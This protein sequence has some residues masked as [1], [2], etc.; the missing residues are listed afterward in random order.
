[1]NDASKPA[2][3]LD[4]VLG[5]RVMLHQPTVGYRVAIDPILL[6]AA[7]PAES[8][9][10]VVDLGCG[11]GTAA[12]CLARR[13][14]DVRCVGV[15]LQADL[16]DLANRNARENDLA[17]RARFLAGD[18]L[19][20]TLPI[21]AQPSD[22]VIVNPPY[23]KRGTATPSDNPAKVLAN[24]EGEADLA[25]WVAAAVRATRPGGTITFI[26]RADRL[27]DLLA[28]LGARCGGLVIQPLHPKAGAAAHRAI[29]AGRLDQRL[30]A[31]LLPGLIVHEA[32]GRF[33][34]LLERVL[35]DGAAL[36]M[37]VGV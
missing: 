11:V 37:T 33:S 18:I 1:M 19:D 31:I 25:A 29:V 2:T 35:R 7:C 17:D 26:H 28:L 30:P 20:R 27:P 36:P 3:T 6:A 23:L 15:D 14:P 8:G 12:L 32:D 16:A 13:V 9:E 22:R 10:T 21:Y 34:P 4:T 24:V 5:G